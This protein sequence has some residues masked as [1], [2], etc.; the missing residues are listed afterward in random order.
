MEMVADPE[1]FEP[2]ISGLEG[3]RVGVGFRRPTRRL[4]LAWPRVP[5]DTGAQLLFK[6]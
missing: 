1:G 4:I 5:T 3:L 6:N 2:S